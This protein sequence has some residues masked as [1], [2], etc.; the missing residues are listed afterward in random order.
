[1]RNIPGHGK[2]LTYY[3]FG[4]TS[5]RACRRDQ[6]FSYCC[7]VPDSFDEDVAQNYRLLVAM[8]GTERDF[9]EIRD[10]FAAFAERHQVIV[11]APLFPIGITHADDLSSYKML[12]AGDLRYDDILLSMVDEIGERYRIDTRRFALCGFSGGGQFSHRFMYLHPSRLHAVSI[13]APGNATLLDPSFPFWIG[14][15]D[16]AAIFGANIDLDAL[17]RLSVQLVVGGADL[18]SWEIAIKPGSPLWMPGVERAGDDRQTRIAA[19]H[20]S[21]KANGIAARLDVVPG[22]AHNRRG[23]LQTVEAF[24][25]TAFA[26]KPAVLGA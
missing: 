2:R 9:S 3:D 17:R 21:L 5:V 15:G 23:V 12:K 26:A 24:L 25:D 10:D 1:M 18:E 13:G 8:H 11:L 14:T 6:R 7:Y 22:V 19:L 16:I 4:A 20:R